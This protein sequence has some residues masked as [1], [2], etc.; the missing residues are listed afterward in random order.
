[1]PIE[2]LVMYT[3]G[4]YRDPSRYL[5][6]R[7]LS[8]PVAGLRSGGDRAPG[9]TAAPPT[10]QA[11]AARTSEAVPSVPAA[12]PAADANCRPSGTSAG[13]PAGPQQQHADT[14]IAVSPDHR[15]VADARRT[16]V[17]EQ[18]GEQ[19][20]RQLG[21]FETAEHVFQTASMPQRG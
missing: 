13:A 15:S 10:A 20:V 11:D 2:L 21:L 19:D 6:L 5:N 9:S 12:S 4:A 17:S 16:R 1:M 14:D 8:P 7:K 18:A 3:Q